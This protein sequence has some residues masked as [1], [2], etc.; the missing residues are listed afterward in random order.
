MCRHLSYLTFLILSFSNIIFGAI[1]QISNDFSSFNLTD[2]SN[3]TYRRFERK[4][5]SQLFSEAERNFDMSPNVSTHCRRDFELYK[6]HLRN[7]STW[8]I[9][10][11]CSL[12]FYTKSDI[13]KNF[14]NRIIL[15]SLV[16]NN[17]FVIVFRKNY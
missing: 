5:I 4:W 6:L 16:A 9:R 13:V 12:I 17:F 14:F 2:S 15:N 3:L 8:A 10:S 1:F 7:Q 11:R